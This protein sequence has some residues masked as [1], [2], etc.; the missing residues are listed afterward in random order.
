[1]F[2]FGLWRH[3]F[4][5]FVTEPFTAV[6]KLMLG[7]VVWLLLSLIWRSPRRGIKGGHR[8]A[9]IGSF[10]G[11]FVS[12]CGAS[13]VY[14][15]LVRADMLGYGV[16]RNNTEWWIGLILIAVWMFAGVETEAWISRKVLSSDSKTSMSR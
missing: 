1:L 8:I 10:G 11:G 4:E 7:G 2:Y 5:P 13:I 9:T 14:A 15:I 16:V 6:K 12:S 3:A